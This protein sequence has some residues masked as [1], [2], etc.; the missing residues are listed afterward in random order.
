VNASEFEALRIGDRVAGQVPVPMPY[1]ERKLDGGGFASG[2]GN[3]LIFER[4]GIVRDGG[5]GVPVFVVFDAQP[6]LPNAQI[7]DA[8]MVDGLRRVAGPT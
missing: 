3:T 8:T 5:G 1:W 7:L 2:G 4:R 6:G